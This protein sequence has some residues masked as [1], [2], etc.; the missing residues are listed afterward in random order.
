MKLLKFFLVFVVVTGA[1]FALTVGLNWTAFKTVFSDPESFSEGSE[2]VEKTYS[3][4]GLMD[5]IELNPQHV[6]AV[7]LNIHDETDYIAYN[8]HEPRV[9]GAI[10]NIFLLLEYARQVEEGF[11]SPDDRINLDEIERFRVSTWYRTGHQTALRNLESENNKARL[12]DIVHLAGRHYSQAVSDWLL[13]HLGVERV[14]NLIYTLAG[15]SVEPII[16]GVGILTTIITRGSELSMSDAVAKWRAVPLHER[17]PIFMENAQRYIDDENFRDEV[18]QR[19]GTIRDRLLIDER[20]VHGL[21]SRAEPMAL[22]NVMASIF[23]GEAISPFASQLVKDYMKW[24]YADPVVQQHATEYGALFE[25]R[26]G[27]LTGIDYG[28]STYTGISYAQTLFFDDLPVAFWLHMSS[29]FMNHDLQRRFIYDLTS[30]NRLMEI[31]TGE[32]ADEV[33]S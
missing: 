13:F 23:R 20:R 22:T 5:Y 15:D 19:A 6:S 16:P 26:L 31:A 27:Y 32:Q 33:E 24:A 30:R 9:M 3:L 25:S 8:A 17:I 12:G 11:L 7:S 21:W 10:G 29:N 4:S 18:T 14:N 2:W 1:I 28:T